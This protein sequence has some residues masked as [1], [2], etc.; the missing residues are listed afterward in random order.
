MN[1]VV[2]ASVTIKWF[3]PETLSDAAER[4]LTGSD[5]L[6]LPSVRQ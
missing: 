1:V 4:L 2:D 3:L 6:F 5:T